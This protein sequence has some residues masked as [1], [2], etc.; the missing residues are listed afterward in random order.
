MICSFNKSLLPSTLR[1]G[2][3][4]SWEEADFR[5]RR[6]FLDFCFLHK[7]GLICLGRLRRESPSWKDSGLNYRELPQTVYSVI[8]REVWL[9][10]EM[11]FFNWFMARWEVMGNR[12]WGGK[13]PPWPNQWWFWQLPSQPG[14]IF[15]AQ[16]WSPSPLSSICVFSHKKMM[17]FLGPPFLWDLTLT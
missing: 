6:K 4:E 15:W 13:P 16:H 11:C 1:G 14:T 2:P 8:W 5:L 17:S 12:F 3:G 10:T 9:K 7:R